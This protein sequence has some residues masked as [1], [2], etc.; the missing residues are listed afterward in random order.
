MISSCQVGHS[1]VD[2]DSSSDARG[3]GF[4]PRP[5]HFKNTAS[6]PRSPTGSPRIRAH[7]QISELSKRDGGQTNT[8]KDFPPFR[9]GIFAPV[10]KAKQ[11]KCMYAS[12]PLKLF[13]VAQRRLPLNLELQKGCG[14]RL[15]GCGS[16]SYSI[17]IIN[18]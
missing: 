1:G 16:M 15:V 6:L 7:P 9:R 13:V 17:T 10:V 2:R 3:S 8:Q 12:I 11:C 5:L 4:K 14:T 18:V